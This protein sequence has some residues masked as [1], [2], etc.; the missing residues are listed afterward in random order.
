[1]LTDKLNPFAFWFRNS[2][3]Y[4]N[5]HRGKT[6]VVWFDGEAVMSSQFPNLI[7][8]IALLDSLGIRLVLVHGAR[9]Q[10][11]ARLHEQGI[12][13]DY[14]DGMRITLN[15]HL[16]YIKE[17]IATTR[18]EI[19]ALLSMGVANSPMAGAN[20]RVISGNFIIAQPLGIRNGVDFHHSGEVRRI[21]VVNLTGWLDA[22]NIILLSPIGFSPTGEV[23]NLNAADVA[24]SAAIAL[25]ADK[26]LCLTEAGELKDQDNRII[27]QLTPDAAE[28]LLQ[29]ESITETVKQHLQAAIVCCRHGVRR[30][31][32]INRQIDGALLLELFSRDG[33]GTMV[34]SDVY[35]ET[36]I[37]VVDDIGGILELITPLEKRGYLVRRSRDHFEMEIQQFFVIERDGMII[38]CAALYPFVGDAMA[39]VGCFAI[40]PDYRNTGRGA[41]L[42]AMLEKQAFASGISRLFVLTTRTEHWFR[43]K[44]YEHLDFDA[45]P[46]ERM[47]LYN[48]QRNSKVFLKVLPAQP[49]R[50]CL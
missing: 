7:H 21:D 24:T 20:I 48:Y 17:S 41:N 12:V 9:V 4:I 16:R 23:F 31:H 28:T 32:L 42:L 18:V 36:R 30:A 5:A 45:L 29:R 11:D 13:S 43:E 50:Q 14:A 38:G 26:L 27:T 44:G 39:E 40:H 33:I 1:M 22:K 3:P 19:E 15:E 2:A 34:T 46:I 25:Q 47:R 6:F 37:A 8:D 35:E 10:V 49:V